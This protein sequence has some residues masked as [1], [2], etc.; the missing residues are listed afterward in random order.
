M[1]WQYITK[2]VKHKTQLIFMNMSDE[3]GFCAWLVET[4]ERDLSTRN[5][6]EELQQQQQKI[7]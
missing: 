1:S 6:V 4:F 5:G 7:L 2:T 3:N